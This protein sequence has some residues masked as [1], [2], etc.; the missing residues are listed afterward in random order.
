MAAV[1]EALEV[2]LEAN[3]PAPA[4]VVDRRWNMVAANSAMAALASGVDPALLVPPVNVM[5]VG[6]HPRGFARDILNLGE[7]RGYFIGRLRRQVEIG[8]DEYLASLLAEVEAY[9][10]P[11]HDG[12]H[13]GG[14]RRPG[15]YSLPRS[16]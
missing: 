10:G 5:R 1:R 7:V 4:V 2:I 12:H 8:G 3:E 16:E 9:P 11:E 6:L 14:H 15:R 13:G